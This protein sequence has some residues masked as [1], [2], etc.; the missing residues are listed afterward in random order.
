M[1]KFTFKK[2]ETTNLTNANNK[3]PE[4]N[5]TN[6]ELSTLK[7]STPFN[8]NNNP[9]NVKETES[10]YVLKKNEILVA[11]SIIPFSVVNKKK[12]PINKNFRN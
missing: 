4:A 11:K 2:P 9:D 1:R 10:N 5:I 8:L 3:P 12:S 7:N 6:G